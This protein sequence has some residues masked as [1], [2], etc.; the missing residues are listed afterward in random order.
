[1]NT[2]YLKIID[3]III[4]PRRKFYIG[5][6]FDKDE[7]KLDGLDM[8]TWRSVREDGMH[9]EGKGERVPAAVLFAVGAAVLAASDAVIVRALDGA[10]HPFV[11]A[12]FRALFGAAVLLRPMVVLDH[13][14]TGGTCEVDGAI[15]TAVGDD[16]RLDRLW[17]E[18]PRQ[19]YAAAAS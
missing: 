12:F 7:W 17:R 11:I 10:V 16:D 19:E 14:G 8:P 18:A 1:M 6:S 9:A 13:D 3:I 4:R 2:K 15:G 5:K